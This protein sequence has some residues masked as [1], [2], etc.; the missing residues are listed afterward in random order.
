M[1]NYLKETLLMFYLKETLLCYGALWRHPRVLA[2][3]FELRRLLPIWVPEVSLVVKKF[4]FKISRL[5]FLL[6]AKFLRAHS[7]LEFLATDRRFLV[8][9]ILSLLNKQLSELSKRLSKLF[10]LSK[11]LSKLLLLGKLFFK[12]SK[13]LLLGKLFFKLSK[14]LFEHFVL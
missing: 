6:L 14:L 1:N 5:H 9:Y 10:L 2:S 4:F 11:R 3:F 7:S 8:Q 13:L 12:L